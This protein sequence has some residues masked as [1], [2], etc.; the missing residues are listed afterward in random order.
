MVLGTG[1]MGAALLAR[2][3]RRR[4]NPSEAARNA[5]MM[6]GIA[7][8]DPQA[9]ANPGAEG[10]DVEATEAAHRDV[11]D[12]RERLPRRGENVR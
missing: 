11:K 8:V 5:A 9:L 4:R 1:A 3:L 7:D 10:I 6:S 12:L 2:Y